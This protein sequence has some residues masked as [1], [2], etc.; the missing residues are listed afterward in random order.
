MVIWDRWAREAKERKRAEMEANAE[1]NLQAKAA[2]DRAEALADAKAEAEEE[3]MPVSPKYRAMERYSV[4]FID[5][6]AGGHGLVCYGGATSQ[7]AS[8]LWQLGQAEQGYG[9]AQ[10]PGEF[11][12]VESAPVPAPS[13]QPEPEKQPEDWVK[14]RFSGIE[15]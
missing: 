10:Q 2:Q 7:E 6:R 3:L 1:A 12:E 8:Y 4:G 15:Y 11:R 5:P 9:Q 13:P 14:R